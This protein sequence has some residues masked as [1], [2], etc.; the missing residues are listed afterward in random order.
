MQIKNDARFW[1]GMTELILTELVSEYPIILES[2]WLKELHEDMKL[3]G[4]NVLKK[5]KPRL[6]KAYENNSN[7]Q[8]P[9]KIC[10]NKSSNTS[11]A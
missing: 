6:D 2:V 1:N 8:P 4:C 11:G 5:L 10:A 3:N 7:K 9:H